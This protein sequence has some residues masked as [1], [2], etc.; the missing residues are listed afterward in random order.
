MSNDQS[1]NAEAEKIYLEALELDPSNET[2]LT[3]FAIFKCNRFVICDY[4]YLNCYYYAL[5]INLKK[6][7]IY[8]NAQ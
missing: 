7:P 5:E 4:F 8:M 6:L 2:V 1:N 3:M